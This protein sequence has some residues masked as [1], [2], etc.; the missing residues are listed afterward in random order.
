MSEAQWPSWM[1]VV[2]QGAGSR[3]PKDAP[4]FEEAKVDPRTGEP[5]GRES[6]TDAKGPATRNLQREEI[7]VRPEAIYVGAVSSSIEVGLGSPVTGGHS[8]RRVRLRVR[9]R[10][11]PSSTDYWLF[12]VV[13]KDAS[14][15]EAEIGRSDTTAVEVLA[16]QEYAVWHMDPGVRVE[17]LHEVTLKLTKNG[18]AVTLDDL[19]VYPDWVVGI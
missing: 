18:S 4:E 6:V 16:N 17:P 2:Q 15:G 13:W 10:V 19:T 12:Q 5:R 14:G 1:E 8:I 7:A 9:T 11:A 3:A